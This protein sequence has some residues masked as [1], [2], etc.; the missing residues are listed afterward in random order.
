MRRLPL[1]LACFAAT[2]TALRLT[3]A[4]LSRGQ[5]S[6]RLYA[7]SGWTTGTDPD[8]R[9][10]YV[11][12][13][14]GQSQWEPPRDVPAGFGEQVVW[15]IT[16]FNGVCSEYAVRNGE[17]QILGRYDMLEQK[18]TVSRA[19]CVLRVA[20]DGTATLVSVGRCPTT[21]R[22]R[23]G[24]P[25]FGLEANYPFPLKAFQ[26]VGIDPNEPWGA[27]FTCQVERA[28]GFG[29]PQPQQQQR[30]QGR[31]G[32]VTAFDEATGEAY[33][34]NEQTGQSQWEPP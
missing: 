4:P 11:D 6:G 18:L 8:G 1:A 30:H 28:D 23:D 25:C 19:Q 21:V 15:R 26:Y 27:V 16:P 32:W 14:T 31:G 10:F 12:G 2:A 34:I 20:D 33:Y 22:P 7:Q 17:E 24:A 9:V 29:Y 3:K 13:R 5:R